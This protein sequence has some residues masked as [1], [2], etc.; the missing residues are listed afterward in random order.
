MYSSVLQLA[1]VI[2][3]AGILACALYFI[4]NSKK[5]SRRRAPRSKSKEPQIT[6]L[7]KPILLDEPHDDKILAKSKRFDVDEEW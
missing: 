7:S 2:I 3:N 5:T 6:T 4:F 1:E